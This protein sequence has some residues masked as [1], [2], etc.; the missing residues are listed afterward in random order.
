MKLSFVRVFAALLILASSAVF[1]QQ[2]F[3][4]DIVDSRQKDVPPHISG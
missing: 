1:A 3:S 4:A 2:D